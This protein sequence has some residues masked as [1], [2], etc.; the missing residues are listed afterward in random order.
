MILFAQ[1][2][3]EGDTAL[4]PH[5]LNQSAFQFER[6]VTLGALESQSLPIHESYV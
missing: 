2:A 4:V 6:A 5:V 1:S 3:L